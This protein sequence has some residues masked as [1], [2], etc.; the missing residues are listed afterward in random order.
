MLVHCFGAR[1][2]AQLVARSVP[3]AATTPRPCAAP[4]VPLQANPSGERQ[5]EPCSS[6]ASSISRTQLVPVALCVMMSW[7]VAGMGLIPCNFFVLRLHE[8][9][10]RDGTVLFVSCIL[11]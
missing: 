9:C 8:L 2:P 1:L 4:A 6:T 10:R 7:V 5:Q 3:C 11:A